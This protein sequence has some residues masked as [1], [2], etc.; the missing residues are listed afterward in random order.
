[1]EA[2]IDGEVVVAGVGDIVIIKP[3]T[4]PLLHRHR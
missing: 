1:V 3:E 2:T 4:P